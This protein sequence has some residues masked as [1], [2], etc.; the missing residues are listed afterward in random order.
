MRSLSSLI[1][2]SFLWK[3][4]EKGRERPQK[5]PHQC[6]LEGQDHLP[7]PAVHTSFDAAQDMAGFLGCESILL[8][9]VQLA[10]HQYPQVFSAG[11][12]S[13]LSS[14]SLHWQWLLPLPRC[15]T[16]HLELLKLIMFT[17]AHCPS[18][19]RSL[20]MVSQPSPVST[21][22]HSLESSA[23]L[24]RVHSTPSVSLMGILRV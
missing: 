19:S 6:R 1:H 7:W 23:N 24:P 10:I 3:N 12:C 13:T 14:L 4:P 8:A 17:W 21:A 5:R 22:P 18:L 20:W 15:K 11:L 2:S 9:H 16:L